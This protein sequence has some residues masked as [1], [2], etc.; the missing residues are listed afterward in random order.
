VLVTIQDVLLRGYVGDVPRTLLRCA[1]RNNREAQS[2]YNHIRTVAI[3][4]DGIT[5]F[6]FI[7]AIVPSAYQPFLPKLG[8]DDIIGFILPI[9]GDVIGTLYLAAGKKGCC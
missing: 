8:L 1:A 7:R 3:V 6:E 4:L 9:A 5:V 2:L